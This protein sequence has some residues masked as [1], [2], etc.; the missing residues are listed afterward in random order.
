MELRFASDYKVI[1]AKI[2]QIG[3]LKYGKTRKYVNGDVTYLSPYI[4]R[5]NWNIKLTS[6]SIT[7]F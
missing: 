7:L 4:S 2:N 5:D 1:L 3:S 6:L